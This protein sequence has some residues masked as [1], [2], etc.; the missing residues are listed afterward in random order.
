MYAVLLASQFQGFCRDL[1]SESVDFVVSMISPVFQRT[2]QAAFVHNCQLDRGN[3][4]PG[5][6]GA[7]FGRLG[8]DLWTKADN[9]DPDNGLRRT[10]L[11]ELNQ[12]RNAIVHEDFDPGKLGGTVTLQLRRVKEWRQACDG[13]SRSFD[14]IM[15]DHFHSL[16]GT[17]PW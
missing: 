14:I 6:V 11:D 1:H 17:A 9:H 4:Q 2:T 8:I 7:D 10:L 15:R 5:S 13:L 16:T 3:A 12:W